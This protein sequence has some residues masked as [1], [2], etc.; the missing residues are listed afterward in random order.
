MGQKRNNRRSP[1]KPDVRRRE[2]DV[3]PKNSRGAVPVAPNAAPSGYQVLM[4]C[5]LLLLAVGLVFGQTIRHEFVNYDDDTYVYENP[6]VARGLTAAGVA[7]VFTHSHGANWHPLTG[8][9]HMVDCQLHGLDAGGHHETNVVLHAA[10]AIALFLLLWRMTGGFWP[11]ALVAAIFAVHPLRVES[12]AW[13]A[14]RKDVLSGL[15][16]VA[17]LAAYVWYVRSTFSL[18]RYLLLLVVFALGLMAKPMLVTLPLLLLLLDYWPLGRLSGS[19]CLGPTPAATPGANFPEAA[20]G[21]SPF[22]RQ[23][24]IEKL[25]LLLLAAAFCAVT[26]WAQGQALVPTDRIPFPW[27][28]ANA[29]VSYVAYLGQFVCPAGLA[30]FY[31]HPGNHLPLMQIVGAAVVLVGISAATLA[32]RRRYPYLLMGWLWY[33]GMLLPVIGLVQVGL[34]AMADRYTYLPQIGLCIALAWGAADLGRGWPRRREACGI[35]SMIVLVVLMACA[36]RQASFWRNSETLWTHA[37]ACTSESFSAHNNLGNALVSQGRFDEALPHYEQALKLKPN[38]AK[39]HS[40]LG[41]ALVGQRRFEEAIA[42]YQKAL[43]LKPD[44]AKVYINLGFA[45]AQQGRLP[46]AIGYY[47]KALETTPDD[48]EAYYNLG[49]ALASQGQFDA[50]MAQYQKALEIKPDFVEAH[51]NLGM[52][53]A[54]QRQFDAAM[55]QYRQALQINPNYFQA[56]NNLGYALAG[57]GRFDEAIR[58]YRK[59]LQ[60]QPDCAMVHRNLGDALVAQGRLDDAIA[61]YQKTLQLQPTDAVAHFNLGNALTRRDR[62]DE[63]AICYR[64]ALALAE[65]QHDRA[66]ADAARARLGQQGAEK[67]LPP[68]SSPLQGPQAR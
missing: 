4:V 62:A 25:P 10:T 27:R 32:Y 44:L 63:A 7:W 42:H 12:V 16:F 36:W 34:Q 39:T 43:A 1:P 29:L 9:S 38:E 30:V 20:L 50:A 48:V 3:L 31:P 28:M 19:P 66:V 6:H 57:Q 11:S 47:H 45:S 2:R 51:S 8:L 55:A 22:P 37:L 33:V 53:L 59:A 40:N 64:K 5:A 26:V 65:Q 21:R 54:S 68:T 60:I 13:V 67:P 56:R 58:H 61:H 35:A 18:G 15:C 24:V 46:E 17:T 52:V 41:N 14:E 49:L 23:V